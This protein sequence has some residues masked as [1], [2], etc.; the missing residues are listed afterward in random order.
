MARV[1]P[2]IQWYIDINKLR[3]AE[4]LDK[5]PELVKALG[6]YYKTFVKWAGNQRFT[7]EENIQEEYKEFIDFI[8]NKK[9]Y[10]IDYKS[11]KKISEEVFKRDNY[12]CSYCGQVGG[13]LEIDHII[14]IFKN[15]TNDLNNL[16]TACRKCNRQKKDKTAEEFNKWKRNKNKESKIIKNG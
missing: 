5:H 13:F 4:D 1:K 15:G 7:Y 10:N 3:V 12:T 9:L 16:T 2:G 14:P 11:W 8:E 6:G